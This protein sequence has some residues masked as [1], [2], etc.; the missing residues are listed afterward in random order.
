[1][2]KVTNIVKLKVMSLKIKDNKENAKKDA[3]L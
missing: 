2:N 1:M 3:V